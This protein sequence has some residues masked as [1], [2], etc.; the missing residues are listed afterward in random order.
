M[1]SKQKILI[2]IF[3]FSFLFSLNAQTDNT[4]F[5]VS[6]NYQNGAFPI[7]QKNIVASIVIDAAEAKVVHIAAACFTN[8][9]QLVTNN[10]MQLVQQSSANAYNIVAGTIGKSKYIDEL[11]KANKIN[12]T[13]IQNK[14]ECFLIKIIEKKLLII[15]SDDRGTA[16]GIFEL[17]RQIGVHPF[18]WWADIK[19]EYKK[20]LFVTGTLLQQSP[21]IQYRGIFLNDEDWGLQ[22]W[23]A[24]KMDTNIKDIGPKT[25]EK[26]FELL[27]R[28]KANCIW[29]AMHDCTK[30]F[31]Y[32][33]ENGKVAADYS[34][35]V[36]TSHCEPMMR[37]NV[38]EWK[39]NYKNEYGIE[40]K[41]WRYDSNKTQIYQYWNDRIKAV[42][43]YPTITTIGMRGI[44]DG[45]MPGPKDTKGKVSL[46]QEVIKDQ[47]EIL[48]N[49]YQKPV[50]NIP[51]IFCP[52]K[53][54]LNLYNA[55]LQ[56]PEDISLV[57]SDDNYGY[58]RQL[59]TAAERKRTGGSGVYYHLSY[60]G[61]PHDYLWLSTI[62]P[63]LI[64]YEMSK[65][66]AFDAKKLWVVNVG[67]IKPNE[68]EMQFF[69][70]MAWNV[71]KWTPTKAKDYTEQWAAE[72]FGKNLAPAIAY[73][74]N[75]FY[76]LAA[77]CK[78]EH[79]LKINLRD[80]TAFRRVLQY[81][82]IA[83]QATALYKMV[84]E[85][86]QDAFFQLVL[87][88]IVGASLM[89]EKHYY[90]KQSLKL[91]NEDNKEAFVY[92]AKSKFAFDSIQL[93]TEQY[94]K[95]IANAK[96]DGMMSWKP[97]NLDVFKMP[98][99]AKDGLQKDTV[100]TIAK[101]STEFLYFISAG[102]FDKKQDAGNN[103]ITVLQGLGVDGNGICSMPF[104]TQ[105]NTSIDY[106]K[107]PFVEYNLELAKGSYQLQF[108]CL[109]THN[110]N[111]EAVIQLAI[112]ID[113]NTPIVF[114]LEVPADTAPW[115]KNVVQGYVSKLL[116]VSINNN[117]AVIR[118]YFPTSGVVL[119]TIDVLKNNQ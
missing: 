23:A 73:V 32:Y 105:F 27:L 112:A 42:K 84:P 109:P 94:N 107:T 30:A 66:Y 33:P 37:N 70:E 31:Y 5:K 69:L 64:S 40:P 113:G 49:N 14:W 75:N 46:L 63:S 110:V 50:N 22:P 13:A 61:K 83:Q 100:A 82:S 36:G 55:G 91:Y 11:I 98:K 53:E 2:F 43:N 78:P 67:D 56:V 108:N 117:K 26:I 51:Q 25:Y 103:K 57:W 65:A 35:V 116:P 97:R 9:V 12:V 89:E 81:Q 6:T 71:N 38:F 93:I 20:Q 86:L 102:N 96:W 24:N 1:K 101:S 111:K 76:R 60:W 115:E 10:K 104:T 80:S 16:F 17:S 45:S 18:Y 34:I 4:V 72:I 79:L 95:K 7:V 48:F 15:G 29:P 118:V 106:A 85:R 19:P 41:S 28:L 21:S 62:S 39:E 77:E 54:V 119:N 59:S 68:A 87:Y 90:A 3:T 58:L 92:S 52:Y 44:H 74:K 99:V 114:N 88:P 8:D 47:R